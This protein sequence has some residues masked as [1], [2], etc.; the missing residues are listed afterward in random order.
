VYTPVAADAGATLEVTV[1]ATGPGGSGQ[2]TSNATATV[3]EAP[4]N[5]AVPTISGSAVQ[6]KTLTASPG[7]WAAYPAPAYSYQ[8]QRCNQSGGS[9]ANISAATASTYVL[10]R[11][12]MA[13]T[14]RVAVTAANNVG[15]P[16][17]AASATTATVAGPPVNTSV[18]LVSG[19]TT[20]GNTL[21]TTSG[22][23]TGY[24]TPTYTYQWRRCN[25]LGEAC[26]AIS[27]ATSTTY[28]LT[29]A[30]VGFTLRAYVTAANTAGSVLARSAQTAVIQPGVS[31]G[32]AI[33]GVAGGAPQ[34]RIAADAG[35]GMPALAR[36][37]I[38]LPGGM[39]FAK[40]ENVVHALRVLDRG[41]HRLAVS[42]SLRHG[43]LVLVLH[44]PPRSLTVEIGAAAL[45]VTHP[46][47]V[48]VRDHPGTVAQL[49]L[50]V[51]DASGGVVRLSVRF[52][53]R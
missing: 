3:T 24:P 39:S 2:A 32:A 42:A 29:S 53:L 28:T 14:V 51:T 40:L 6:G 7:G 43:A 8:W 26:T 46:V 31:T 41:G 34:L 47:E 13:N 18:P 50:T 10:Q 36:V 22:A 49:K 20:Q 11:T 37:V 15:T 17:S 44:K 21:T 12:D 9:C 19:T 35:P 5:T 4:Q 27:G 30:D 1:T 38:K 48:R 33:L 25:T 16:S 52:R 45:S 23:W